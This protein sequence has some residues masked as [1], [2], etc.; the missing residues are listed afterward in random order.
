M[1]EPECSTFYDNLDCAREPTV[2]CERFFDLYSLVV[3]VVNAQFRGNIVRFEL[4]EPRQGARRP[5]YT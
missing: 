1:D 3:F 4:K 2:F 5:E